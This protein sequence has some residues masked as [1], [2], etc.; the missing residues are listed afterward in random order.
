MSLLVKETGICAVCKSLLQDSSECPLFT[1]PDMWKRVVPAIA[2]L[3]MVLTST[4]IY[5]LI[6][7]R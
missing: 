7:H 6:F 1:Q 5:W 4:L 2:E 3:F